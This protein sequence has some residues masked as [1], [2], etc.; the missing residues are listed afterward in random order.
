[1]CLPLPHFAQAL[2]AVPPVA[3]L[4]P[5]ASGMHA[6]H[7]ESSACLASSIVR[8]LLTTSLARRFE[9]HEPPLELVGIVSTSCTRIWRAT[10]S[11]SRLARSFWELSVAVCSACLARISSRRSTI[12][13]L[14]SSPSRCGSAVLL[15]SLRLSKR[16][17]SAA[18]FRL[19]DEGS[20][21]RRGR[22]GA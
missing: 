18:S 22:V 2:V 20:L 7:I 5:F 8:G 19:S 6:R 11:W 4:P 14:P 16:W 1:M 21:R 15:R 9:S 17:T 12:P 3:A 13:R 10:L